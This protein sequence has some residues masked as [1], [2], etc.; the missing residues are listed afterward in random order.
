[1]QEK[2]LNIDWNKIN[3]IEFWDKSDKIILIIHWWWW[4][5][6]S[7]I[8]VSEL[9]E[10]S[11]YRV[12]VPDLPWFWKTVLNH[13]FTL[14]DYAKI[15]E[16]FVSILWLSKIILLWHSNGWAISIKLV[17]SGNMDIKKLILNNS[18]WIR[19]KK[20]TSYKK[21][22]LSS[23]TKS[24]KFILKLPFWHKIKNLF[25][26]LIWWHD[27]I[28]SEKN[29]Y[30]KET[31]LNMIKSDLQPD[32][33]NIKIDTLLIRWD[34]DTYTPISDWIWMSKNI[35]NSKLEI[36]N[37]EKHGI[38]LQNPEKLVKNILENI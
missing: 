31:Y 37:W 30:L 21:I 9:L 22:I 13:T 3:Y 16:D 8:C 7:W 34:K 27:Y 1:M 14:D 17:N 38:H 10:K 4:S 36:L 11:W 28:N 29:P 32:I 33:K 12:I 19:D 20:S 26:R 2:I 24:F 23:L 15:I 25:Y 35:E 5:S 6:N 18:A